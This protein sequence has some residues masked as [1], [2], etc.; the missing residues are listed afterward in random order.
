MALH[1]MTRHSNKSF[2]WLCGLM[3]CGGAS[4][5]SSRV[6]V[7]VSKT[8]TEIPSGGARGPPRTTT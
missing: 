2:Q 5:I 3:A 8:Y 6:F 4:G 1:V 7:S